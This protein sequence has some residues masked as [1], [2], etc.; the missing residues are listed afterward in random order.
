VSVALV[1]VTSNEATPQTGASVP[2]SASWPEPAG[3]VPVWLVVDPPQL[4]KVS[5]AT[6]TTVKPFRCLSMEK[7]SWVAVEPL[8]RQAQRPFIRCLRDNQT[9]RR[10]SALE[11]LSFAAINKLFV[12]PVRERTLF[13]RCPEATG[14]PSPPG[15]FRPEGGSSTAAASGIHFF[16]PATLEKV[17]QSVRGFMKKAGQV[18][19]KLGR[20]A[21][22]SIF[23]PGVFCQ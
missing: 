1:M 9:P 13:R 8:S 5:A 2:I 16:E 11:T 20:R 14:M 23:K 7:S 15:G 10:P 18:A 22:R 4:R 6:M 17:A 21:P 3:V 12:T 19:E